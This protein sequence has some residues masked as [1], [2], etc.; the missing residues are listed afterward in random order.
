MKKSALDEK[1][2]IT[3]LQEGGAQRRLFERK[4]Y[5]HFF[6]LIKQ[7]AW[8]YGLDEEICASV[9]SDTI[10]CVLE[11]VVTHRFEEK[12]SLKSYTYQIFMNKCVDE[13]RRTKT[14][15]GRLV[16]E[17]TEID[18]FTLNLPDQVR[19]ILQQI[20][21]KQEYSSLMQ[22]L[23][24][25]GEKCRQL[26]LLFEDGYSDKE[27]AGQMQYNSAQVVKTTRLRCLEQLREKVFS[28]KSDE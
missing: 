2:I 17:L 7:G 6:Y 25:L 24:E 20:I 21:N 10:L 16:H 28:N 19:N 1:T 12:S 15:K 23:Q 8:K 22:K 13:L 18:A 5:E 9:Y 14:S 4:L 26:L 27:I 3:G 11:N